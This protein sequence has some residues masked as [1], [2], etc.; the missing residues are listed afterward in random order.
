MPCAKEW[1]VSDKVLGD[2]ESEAQYLA[3]RYGV[4]IEHQ[5]SHSYERHGFEVSDKY[6][7]DR[8]RG[9]IFNAKTDKMDPP[10]EVASRFLSQDIHQM[11]REAIISLLQDEMDRKATLIKE[12]REIDSICA[13]TIHMTIPVGRA[14]VR[15]SSEWV[16]LSG[17]TGVYKFVAGQWREV[18]LHPDG[19]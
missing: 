8:A 12:G 16:T 13:M 9:L 4:D 2:R 5:I 11:C 15:D 17:A 14:F 18:T 7:I 1:N 10:K 19:V 3:E 6:L